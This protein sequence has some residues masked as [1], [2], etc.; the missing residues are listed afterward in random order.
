MDIYPASCSIIINCEGI[1][2][3]SSKIQ[4]IEFID[5]AESA[6]KALEKLSIENSHS[7]LE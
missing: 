1:K 4:S 5:L 2:A 3:F 6:L 7:I